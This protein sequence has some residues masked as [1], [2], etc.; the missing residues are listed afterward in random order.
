MQMTRNRFFPFTY[1]MR[2]QGESTEEGREE[3]LSL[4]ENPLSLHRVLQERRPS[5]EFGGNRARQAAPRQRQECARAN[6]V[7]G[8]GGTGRRRQKDRDRSR[9][10]ERS[11]KRRPKDP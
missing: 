3:G 10:G 5:L 9:G 1:D 11:E 8:I 2:A 4:C 7:I 6:I